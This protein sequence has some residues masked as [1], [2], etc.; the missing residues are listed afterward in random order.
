[1]LPLFYLSLINCCLSKAS[2]IYSPSEYIAARNRLIVNSAVIAG[3][4]LISDSR[5]KSS[6]KKLMQHGKLRL[7]IAEIKAITEA[8]G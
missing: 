6:P 5:V 2:F 3:S 4:I 7:A 1:M 8:L